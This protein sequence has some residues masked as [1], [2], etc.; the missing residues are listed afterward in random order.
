L[1]D[2][3]LKTLIVAVNKELSSLWQN[4]FQELGGRVYDGDGERVISTE[5][6]DLEALRQEAEKSIEEFLE[7]SLRLIDERLASKGENFLDIYREDRDRA[8]KI[9]ATV[10]GHIVSI[11]AAYAG[12]VGQNDADTLKQAVVKFGTDRLAVSLRQKAAGLL[13]ARMES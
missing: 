3:Q 11:A 1:F 10:G 2:G 4:R 8:K 6:V 5:L 13:E 7:K 12:K 9:L